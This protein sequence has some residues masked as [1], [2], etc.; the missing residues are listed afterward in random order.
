MSLAS[1]LSSM[2][3]LVLVKVSL[4]TECMIAS[5]VEANEGSLPSV[6]PQV[7]EKVVPL[8]K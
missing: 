6:N 1:S 5:L 7:I 8:S 2:N 3:F 4:L